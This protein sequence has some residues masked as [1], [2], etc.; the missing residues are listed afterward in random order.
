MK[1]V[2]RTQLA[3][4][5]TTNV[6][7]ITFVRRRPE[8]A[9]GRPLTR[10]MLC[11]NSMDLL[12][13]QNGKLSLNFRLPG[14][15]KKIDEMKHNVVVAW[16]IF[17]QDYRNISCDSVYLLKEIPA[18]DEFWKYY[19]EVLIKMSPDEKLQFMDS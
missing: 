17:I 12:N 19:N 11:S 15:P 3:Q 7:E 16:D 10:K 18:N 9:K 2:N 1:K 8:R 4:L 6:C 13:S 5:L 14:G